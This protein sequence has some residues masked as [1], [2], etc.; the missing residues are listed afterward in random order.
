MPYAMLSLDVVATSRDLCRLVFD[1]CFDLIFDLTG[2]F[3]TLINVDKDPRHYLPL[4]NLR[5]GGDLPVH[6]WPI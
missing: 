1:L 2:T 3:T 4:H 5:G 6:Y